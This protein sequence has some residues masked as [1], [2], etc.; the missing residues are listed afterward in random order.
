[1]SENA[2]E[3]VRKRAREWKERER[4]CMSVRGKRLESI[5]NKTRASSTP[6]AT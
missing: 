1:M 2:R 4:E 3:S 5:R 6:N